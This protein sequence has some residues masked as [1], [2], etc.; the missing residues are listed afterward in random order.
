ML[1]PAR[2]YGAKG[3]LVKYLLP[4]PPHH[5]YVEVFGGAATLLF[6][7]EE[8]AEVEVYNDIDDGL[9]NFFTVLQDKYRDGEDGHLLRDLL[10]LTPH[11]RQEYKF[12]RDNWRAK[13]IDEMEK[14]RRFFVVMHQSFSGSTTAGWRFCKANSSGGMSAA[15]S[16][17][18]RVIDRLP[19]AIQ[20][21]RRVQID[22]EGFEKCIKRYDDPETLFYLDPPYVHSERVDKASYANE[23][24][25]DQ[26]RALVAALLPIKGL[27]VL[28]G[29]EHEIYE[30]LEV[31]GWR[32]RL[33]SRP[34]NAARVKRGG[35]RGTQEECVWFSPNYPKAAIRIE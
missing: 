30:P 3:W 11:S 29:Y 14:A 13:G 6:A 9:V 16:R 34:N 18:L 2:W 19:E 17:W 23:M 33:I 4:L 22:G 20:R 32:K 35:K 8:P 7:I 31:A 12:C 5:N 26:H 1:T 28:S 15:T 27:A 21:L 10:L 24:S 25:N